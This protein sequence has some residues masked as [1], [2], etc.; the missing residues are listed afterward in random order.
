MHSR[1][2][3]SFLHLAF[4]ITICQTHKYME[5]IPAGRLGVKNSGINIGENGA[6]SWLTDVYL[7]LCPSLPMKTLGTGKYVGAFRP[8]PHS[9]HNPPPSNNWNF[10]YPTISESPLLR[11]R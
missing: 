2:H 10:D 1:F 11:L 8:P 3:P 5:G 9:S 6:R 7:K 4:L